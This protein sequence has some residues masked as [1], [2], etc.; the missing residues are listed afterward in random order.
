M[1]KNASVLRIRQVRGRIGQTRKQREGLQTLGLRRIGQVVERPDNAAVRGTVRA[2]AH[3]VRVEG[4][5]VAPAAPRL[6]PAETKAAP[7][8]EKPKPAEAA[9]EAEKPKKAEA[10]AATGTAPKT[11]KKTTKKKAAKKTAAKKTTKKKAKT[12]KKKKKKKASGGKS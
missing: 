10:A 12:A 11:A 6:K 7:K 2:I 9:V 3:L 8:A 1:A 5:D 4:D